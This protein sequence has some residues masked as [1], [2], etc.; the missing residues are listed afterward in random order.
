M[1]MIEISTLVVV[2]AV[3]SATMSTVITTMIAGIGNSGHG[4]ASGECQG[5]KCFGCVFHR[6]SLFIKVGEC[7]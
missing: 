4:E 3:V 6:S 5:D 1:T 2:M 7:C